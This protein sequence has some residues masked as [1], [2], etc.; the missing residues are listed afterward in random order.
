MK[1]IRKIFGIKSEEEKQLEL[2]KEEERI[3]EIKQWRIDRE[4]RKYEMAKLRR[5]EQMQNSRLMNENRIRNQKVQ[6]QEENSP[7]DD[8]LDPMNPLSPISPFSIWEDN[9]SQE[10][11]RDNHNDDSNDRNYSSNG[12]ND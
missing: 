12:S 11:D 1:W 3:Q 9:S 5:E 2:Q 4:N 10:D 6:H 8:I 7:F